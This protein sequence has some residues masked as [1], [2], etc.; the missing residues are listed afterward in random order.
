MGGTFLF[1]AFGLES[2]GIQPG[3]PVFSD[4]ANERGPLLSR[5]ITM[6]AQVLDA[7]IG[8]ALAAQGLVEGSKTMPGSLAADAQSP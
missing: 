3:A 1:R 8:F 5:L 6:F 4:A 7:R 2:R